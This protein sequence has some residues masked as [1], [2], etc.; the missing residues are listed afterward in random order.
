FFFKYT[1]IGPVA[2]CIRYISSVILGF[3]VC[4]DTSSL[5]FHPL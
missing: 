2:C 5:G 4:R 1:G 3:I